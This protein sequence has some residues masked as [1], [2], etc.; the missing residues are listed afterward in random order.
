[1]DC[2]KKLDIDATSDVKKIKRAYSNQLKYC[3]PEESPEQFQEL[4][5]AYKQALKLAKESRVQPE[6]EILHVD[7]DKGVA[8]EPS[9]HQGNDDDLK[10]KAEEFLKSLQALIE[11]PLN[12][13]NKS[14][15]DQVLG[16]PELRMLEFRQLVNYYVFYIIAEHFTRRDINVYIQPRFIQELVALFNW[17]KNELG[18]AKYFSADAID[19]V[20]YHAEERPP[21]DI[22]FNTKN[23]NSHP[24]SLN[25][26]QLKKSR[27]PASNSSKVSVGF[28]CALLFLI[29]VE[30]AKKLNDAFGSSKADEFI[31]EQPKSIDS[32]QPQ[33]TKAKTRDSL[34]TVTRANNKA[35]K[36]IKVQPQELNSL[37]I[38]SDTALRIYKPELINPDNAALPSTQMQ[39]HIEFLENLSKEDFTDKENEDN[40]N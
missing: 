23:V 11:H 14:A 31:I 21:S 12:K 40:N 20:M 2:W 34:E 32:T 28:L 24:K 17:D 26:A 8:G 27:K 9:Q 4:N 36:N 37:A 15:W 22:H 39:E 18:L 35:L 10:L 5:T 16:L 33:Q 38:Q 30:G 25:N 6:P 1:M 7:M 29:I 19:L 3:R 13:L